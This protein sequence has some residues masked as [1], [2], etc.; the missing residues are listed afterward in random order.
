[1]AHPGTSHDDH[2][3]ALLSALDDRAPGS[4]VVR[5]HVSCGNRVSTVRPL[6]FRFTARA[7]LVSLRARAVGYDAAAIPGVELRLRRIRRAVHRRGHL[8]RAFAG[9]LGGRCGDR[10][11]N[12][13]RSSTDVRAAGPVADLL[14][15]GFLHAA[16]RD[17]S[18]YAR[19]CIG[20]LPVDSSAYA[21]S[22]HIHPVLRRTRLVQAPH[23]RR[24]AARRGGC[25]GLGTARRTEH[26]RHQG[27][28][29]L[30][31]GRALR[32]LH[33]LPRRAGE[34]EARAALSHDV[35]PDGFAGRGARGLRGRI[36]RAPTLCHLL[37]IRRGPRDHAPAGCVSSYAA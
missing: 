34:H 29:R 28:G 4:S 3:A 9:Q 36:R 16:L 30:V 14:R 12:E 21:V 23:L 22:H 25:D 13:Q 37:R 35:L 31:F 20:P 8:Q 26:P 17:E 11:G 6:E 5:T 18:H 1:M 15:D 10:A 27:S 19:R 24:S 32:L 7:D 33:V 2:R